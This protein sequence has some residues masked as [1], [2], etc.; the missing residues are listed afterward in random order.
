MVP[1][2]GSMHSMLGKQKEPEV[3]QPLEELQLPVPASVEVVTPTT[4]RMR[5]VL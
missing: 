2:L 5:W 4:L 1:S 3:P